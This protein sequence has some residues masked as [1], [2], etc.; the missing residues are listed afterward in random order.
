MSIISDRGYTG[1]GS[2]IIVPSHLR[3]A[4]ESMQ[5][6][7]GVKVGVAVHKR[8]GDYQLEK[9]SVFIKGMNNL[10]ALMQ[11]AALWERW[12]RTERNITDPHPSLRGSARGT[13][14]SSGDWR[15]Y[16]NEA[17]RLASTGR[18]MKVAGMPGLPPIAFCIEGQAFDEE[19]WEPQTSHIVMDTP[20]PVIEVS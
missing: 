6:Q 7:Y 14:L 5:E 4:D 13:N 11:A 16:W 2:L 9:M 1:K 17:R 15:R 10:D 12:F 20:P 8:A 3:E 18:V 19:D